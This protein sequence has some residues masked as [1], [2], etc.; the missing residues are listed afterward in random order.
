V[1]L[2][3][4]MSAQIMQM[5]KMSTGSITNRTQSR[6]K[7]S[8]RRRSRLNGLCTASKSTASASV[9]VKERSRRFRSFMNRAVSEPQQ[10]GKQSSFNNDIQSNRGFISAQQFTEINMSTTQMV[11][12]ASQRATDNT[13]QS[14]F[15]ADE[16]RKGADV[17]VEAL[18]REGVECV[19]AYPGGASME[20]HQALTRSV[21]GIRNV[22][23]RHEQ[24]EVFA[25]EGYGKATGKVGVC[26]A[27]SGPG[28]TN[29]VTGLA[30]ALLDS[31]PMVAIT[32]Q[33]PRAMIGTDA[34]Q[35]T[36]I[37]EITRQIT[38]HNYLVMN[39]EEIPRIIREAFFLAN[40]GRPGP[41]L[42][43]IPKDVQ[44]QMCVPYWQPKV[45][46]NGYLSRLPIPPSNA[47]IEQVLDLIKKSKK[48]IIYSGG[49]CLDA[50]QELT[51][52]ARALGIPVCSTL[53]GL[54]AFP[55]SDKLSLNMLGMHGAVYANYAIDNADL[56]LAFGV[57]FD[58]RVTG[59]LEAF[60]SR[61]SIVHIDIDPAEIGKNKKP[62]CSIF[63]NIKPALKMLNEQINKKNDNKMPDFSE[64]RKEIDVQRKRHP[65]PV[66]ELS[67]DEI[68]PQAAIKLLHEVTNGEAIISTGVGQHQMWAAQ[69][70][71]FDEP[72]NWLSSGGLGSMGFGLPAAIGAAA[73]RP[74]KCVIDIDGDGSFVMNIQ[75]LA[76]LH[77][78]RLPVKC[79]ILNNQYLGMV[80]QWEDRFYKSNRGHTYLGS[81]DHGEYHE[82]KDESLI[83]PDFV[84]IAKGF[85]V[86]AERVTKMSQLKAAI[87]R[88]VNTDGP[89][90]LDIMVPHQE[91]VLPMVPGGGSFKDTITTGDG[92]TQSDLGKKM[93]G[94]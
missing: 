83:F 48:P 28:A 7:K 71:L 58:D 17:L 20:I 8:S 88:M 43:D 81:P 24:G 35:E 27:T 59:K 46:L 37:V 52:F 72:R 49:G 68:S 21:T 34:F 70:Y 62:F 53:M 67:N 16:P 61:A 74:D 64:W 22:L 82:T 92:R 18:E 90:L 93:D 3:I 39:V 41:V 31:V 63:S 66:P 2:D 86:P 94:L 9:A 1:V 85:R 33:V 14:R 45:S 79:F 4:K 76:T 51:D 30:D 60:A 69:H 11:Q 23:C 13:F 56:M 54:G 78:E 10:S 25:A 89:Y 50:S 38:K 80:V 44:Q 57:R 40:S 73:A 47:Q 84:T 36:P 65:F 26:I 15:A 77:A 87:E 32:G 6:D 12:L 91:H 29:L 42:V 5:I 19:F 75:E 55:E